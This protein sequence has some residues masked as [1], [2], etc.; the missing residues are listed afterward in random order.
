MH[1]SHSLAPL[2][3]PSSEGLRP[4]TQP[5]KRMHTYILTRTYITPIPV[6]HTHTHIQW[7]IGRSLSAL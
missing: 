5:H 4:L 7:G 6:I 1:C 2:R 3:L